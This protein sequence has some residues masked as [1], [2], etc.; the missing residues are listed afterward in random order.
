MIAGF[1]LRRLA[2][3]CT[4]VAATFVVLFT[5]QPVA[6][7]NGYDISDGTTPTNNIATGMR[8]DGGLL[9][10]V[11][12]R[13]E[14]NAQVFLRLYSPSSQAWNPPLN[15]PPF[16]V[17]HNGGSRTQFARCAIDGAGTIH[18]VWAEGAGK[19]RIVHR[20][21]RPGGDPNNEGDWSSIEE[22]QNDGDKPDVAAQYSD[23]HGLIWVAY[24]TPNSS[25]GYD[26]QVRRWAKDA[27]WSGPTTI[28]D[29]GRGTAGFPRL[30]VDDA[31]YVNLVFLQ[32]G[33]AGAQ[34]STRDARTGN[35]SPLVQLPGGHDAA[36]NIGITV[37][38]YSGSVHIT[39]V[40]GDISCCSVV[41]YVHRSGHTGTSFSAERALTGGHGYLTTRIAWSP[42]GRLIV[43]AD[44]FKTSLITITS[45]DEG[46]NWSSLATQ[47]DSNVR[48]E[49]PWISAD[50]SGTAYIAYA[51]PRNSS[52]FF[53]TLPTGPQQPSPPPQ[54]TAPPTA[55][56]P[57][58]VPEAPTPLCFAETGHCIRGLFLAYWQAHG[59]L[60][61]NGYPLTDERV[62]VLA[63][64][65]A[66]AVQY[67]ERT[68]LEYHPEHQPPYNVLLGQFGR[69]IHPADPPATPRAGA[70]FFD[71]TGHNL[72]GAFLAYWQ[73]HGG[74]EQFGY[75]ISEEF[76]QTLDNGQ[77]YLVQYFERARLEYH[78][79]NAG[80][81]Y[82]VELGQF[83]RAILA[84]ETR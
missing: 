17:S 61:L 40:R 34:F 2:C 80:T 10:A 16:Q 73:A 18:V 84:S 62:E 28:S 42:T 47:N 15:A 9:C 38:R 23:S 64:G 66:Y 53:T 52:M 63:D 75:P 27:G 21:L 76:V 14:S 7:G 31:G 79:E 51:N 13:F 50:D 39:F 41:Y 44:D 65:N 49:A 45:D 19:L 37:N 46:A 29:V 70:Y 56:A 6:A 1:Q 69:Q 26:I 68:R 54:P 72:G 8:P 3:C 43:V 48:V 55:P 4:L 59:G 81:P 57:P 25:G 67:F 20:M 32:N 30:A 24:Q 35:W 5:P 71:A 58:D 82:A 60:T 78:P 12:T 77:P 36:F 11:W 33:H 74:L 83:G 22:V